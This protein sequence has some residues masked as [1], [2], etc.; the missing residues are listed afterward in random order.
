MTPRGPVAGSKLF[1]R[2]RSM[3]VQTPEEDAPHPPPNHLPRSIRVLC[4]A[5][6]VSVWFSFLPQKKK[7]HSARDLRQHHGGQGSGAPRQHLCTRKGVCMMLLC[8]PCRRVLL[9]QSREILTRIHRCFTIMHH[10]L[11]LNASPRVTRFSSELSR[12]A[13]VFLR[14]KHAHIETHSIM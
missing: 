9:P 10:P 5:R 8:S 11:A 3:F 2:A 1:S 12:V 7:G 13:S 4:S 14:K 6:F